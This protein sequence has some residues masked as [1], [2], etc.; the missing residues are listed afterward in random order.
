MVYSFRYK[1]N[2]ARTKQTL[3][4][5]LLQKFLDE[6][7]YVDP[8]RCRL[9]PGYRMEMAVVRTF[10]KFWWKGEGV[11]H[12]SLLYLI[13]QRTS[14]PST[15]ISFW[16]GFRYGSGGFCAVPVHFL[17]LWPLGVD[18]KQEVQSSSTV[19]QS[20]AGLSTLFTSV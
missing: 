19:L 15:M 6:M 2:K 12:S 9:R 1:N 10:D 8:F 17:P 13:S 11:V 7:D 14:I 5:I 4:Y 20:A 16:S 18:R 3:I